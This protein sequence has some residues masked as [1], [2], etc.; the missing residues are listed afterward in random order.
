MASALPASKSTR[1]PPCRSPASVARA[2]GTHLC[3]LVILIEE[4]LIERVIEPVPGPALD[5][6]DS[7]LFDRCAKIYSRRFS[8]V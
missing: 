6:I 5:D 2:A 4:L 7:N 1:E 3:K 8:S